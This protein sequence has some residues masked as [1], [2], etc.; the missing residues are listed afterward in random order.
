MKSLSFINKDVKQPLG[1]T[2]KSSVVLN[3][4]NSIAQNA[5]QN[6]NNQQN[7]SGGGLLGGFSSVLGSM[8]GSST[9][10]KAN[11]NTISNVMTPD[12]KSA[13]SSK[14]SYIHSLDGSKSSSP[15]T[16]NLL[17]P[18]E[19]STEFDKSDKHILVIILNKYLPI[20]YYIGGNTR[21]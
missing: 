9:P 5:H 13:L 1:I 2:T 7:Q 11:S 20:I 12:K 21:K 6:Q 18:G 15:R 16:L 17:S 19:M 8:F 4:A 3:Y 14:A 10:S